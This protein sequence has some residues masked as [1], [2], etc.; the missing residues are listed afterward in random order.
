[1]ATVLKSMAN[2]IVVVVFVVGVD[3]PVVIG[4]DVPARLHPPGRAAELLAEQ[5]HVRDT[6]GRPHQPL[7]LLGQVAREAPDA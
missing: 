6:L 2:A 7:L 5:V 1:M 3:G 4:D